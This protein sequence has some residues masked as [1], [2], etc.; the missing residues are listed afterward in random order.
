MGLGVA[1]EPAS[2]L[3]GIRAHFEL[4]FSGPEGSHSSFA[5]FQM[6][7]AH[8]IFTEHSHC[9]ATE[10][11]LDKKL[12]SASRVFSVD[13]KSRSLAFH[14]DPNYSHNATLVRVVSRRGSV[15][16]VG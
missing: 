16:G 7:P 8:L 4:N 3:R 9:M 5:Q 15:H 13:Y 2:T 10:Q 12:S 6:P 14:D 11:R 1:G